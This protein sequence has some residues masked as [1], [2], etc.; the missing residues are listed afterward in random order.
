MIEHPHSTVVMVSICFGMGYAFF[1]NGLFSIF[2]IFVLLCLLYPLQQGVQSTIYWV[3]LGAFFFGIT[4]P[5]LGFIRYFDL[6]DWLPRFRY[7]KEPKSQQP[8]NTHSS[9]QTE[10]KARFEAEQRARAEAARKAHEAQKKADA[11][12][13]KDNAQ[14]Q[15]NQ[16]SDPH[17]SQSSSKWQYQH[18][19]EQEKIEHKVDKRTP[20]EVLGLKPGYTPADVKQAYRRLSS[21][22][23]PD[24]WQN[25]PE[26]IRAMMN[27]EMKKVNWACSYLKN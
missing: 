5:R 13:A 24:K 14:Q 11:Q 7:Q 1:K 4:Y 22:Y 19:T 2:R 15:E 3:C 25:E 20:E 9:Q 10:Q 8:N 26:H 17:S 21:R 18:H 12:Q 16:Q 23:H 6:R 27:A